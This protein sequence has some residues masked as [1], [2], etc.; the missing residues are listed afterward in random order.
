MVV[1]PFFFLP[2]RKKLTVAAAVVASACVG[3][4]AAVYSH[5]FKSPPSNRRRCRAALIVLGV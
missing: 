4:P 5:A 1:Y 2:F 3:W